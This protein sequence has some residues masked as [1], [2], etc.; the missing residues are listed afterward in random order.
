MFAR[1]HI[2]STGKRE[3]KTVWNTANTSTGSSSSTQVKLPLE[4]AGVYSFDVDWGDG[5]NDTITTWNQAETTHT[6]ST[7]GTYTITITGTIRGWSFNNTGDKLKP[8]YID[9]YGPLALLGEGAFYGCDNV[10]VRATDA[11]DLSYTTTL[12]RCWEAC[13][14][15]TNMG[16]QW[17]TSTITNIQAWW[18]NAT[19]MN[20]PKVVNCDFSNVV[21]GRVAFRGTLSFTYSVAGCDWS[22]LDDADYMFLDSHYNQALSTMSLPA[23]TSMLGFMQDN[24]HFNNSLPSNTPLVTDMSY[25]LY[26]STAFQQALI[27]NIQSVTTFTN[28][29]NGI[30]LTTANYDTTLEHFG[31]QSIVSG[32]TIS[33]GSATYTA[34]EVVSAATNTGSGTTLTDTSQSFLTTVSAGDVVRNDTTGNYAR[35]SSVDSNTQLTLDTAI[36][37]N[38]DTYAVETSD[39]AKARA[40]MVIDYNTVITDGGPV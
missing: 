35:V 29:L 18:Q 21:V 40:A 37:N 14:T 27:I 36:M 7:A 39:S 9:A 28:W 15:V 5:N 24:T 31:G 13:G 30:T 17:R 8:T 33:F 10:E 16:G 26:Q 23:A 12:K 19:N 25:L 22:S 6:Y 20:D 38:T 34:S 4:S 3:F 32:R 1:S 2:F 11:P